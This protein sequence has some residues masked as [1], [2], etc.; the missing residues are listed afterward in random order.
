[1][2]A[3][4]AAAPAADAAPTAPAA[5]PIT[6]DH[7]TTIPA[8]TE[9]APIPRDAA[10]LKTVI[11]MWAKTAGEMAESMRPAQEAEQRLLTI[12][13][14]YKLTTS[15]SFATEKAAIGSALV[16]LGV[17]ED[18]VP[19]MLGNPAQV[20]LALH[21]N[22]VKTLQTLK[23]TTSRFTQM[24]FKTLSTN[25]EH[26][27]LQPEANA[28]QL[29]EDIG[30]LR[31]QQKLATDWWGAAQQAG[32]R[33]PIDFQVKWTKANPLAKEVDAVKQEI[34]PLKGMKGADLPA[35]VPQGSKQIGTKGGN[36][37]YLTPDNKRIMVTP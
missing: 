18:K 16:A 31:Q 26:P 25:Q 23:A 9:Q 3:P 17:P 34:G 35:G 4:A 33:N 11:P 28:Q 20:Q 13:N 15:G 37:V 7:G 1:M 19:E 6:T 24:E 29:A 27:N 12:A 36:P 10:S 30:I 5:K 14:A 32:W 21:E 8:A 2:R 22:A